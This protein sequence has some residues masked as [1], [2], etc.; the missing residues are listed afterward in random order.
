MDR[1]W[2]TPRG[3]APLLGPHVFGLISRPI[4][5]VVQAPNTG[6]H[7]DAGG[8]LGENFG[9][10]VQTPAHAPTE[11]WPGLQERSGPP[12]GAR[13]VKEADPMA[14]NRPVRLPFFF[15]RGSFDP[16]PYREGKCGKGTAPTETR[17]RKLIVEVIC[18]CAE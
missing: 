15:Y 3:V 2:T 8:D 1:I 17:M 9:P 5:P 10:A 12:F 6:A 16:G 11:H 4:Q 14:R 18:P 13:R 7:S